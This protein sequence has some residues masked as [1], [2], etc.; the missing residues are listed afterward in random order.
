MLPRFK[1]YDLRVVGHYLGVLISFFSLALLLP[2]ITAVCMQEWEAASR[3]LLGAGLTLALGSLMRMLRIEPGKLTQSQALAITGFAWIIL[4]VVA[5]VPLWLSGHYGS[6]LD[7]LF[8]SVSALTTTGAT[9]V[10]DLEH[11]SYADNMWRFTMHFIGGLG[12]IV[13][14]LSLGLLGRSAWGMYL[15]EGRSDHVLPNVVNTARLISG[16]AFITIAIAVV[17]LGIFCLFSGMEPVRAFFH[18]LWIAVSGYMTAGF[19]PT[20]QSIMYYHSFPLEVVCILLMVLGA[21]NFALLLEV[22][23]GKTKAF[24]KDLEIRTAALWLL[25]MCVVLMASMSAAGIYSDL[26]TL[27]R[28]GVFMLISAATT[29]GFQVVTNNQLVT[30]FSSGAIL[31]LAVV[32]AV[33]GSSGS[34]SGGIKFMRI[35]LI[36]KAVVSSVKET[37]LPES[38]RSSVVYHHLTKHVLTADNIKIAT[39][40]SALFIITYLLGALIGI[41]HG[42]DAVASI[43]ESVAMASNGGLSSGIISRGMPVGLEV[44]YIIE[45]WAGRLEFI[46]LLALFVKIV[47]SCIPQKKA[48][49]DK[50]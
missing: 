35:G 2:L 47:A 34:T 48:G 24:F 50:K 16:I 19:A 5:A 20:S 33:G 44:F 31:I 1:L 45:M 49:R 4:A 7:T 40:V 29:T 25:V 36:A 9:L 43:F 12:L 39:T 14:A 28:R 30:V 15:S 18:S 3:Y 38:A 37:L 32:M 46:A 13:V 22:W 17:F 21:I 8:E 6:F 42:Y 23:K 41:A 10:V 26:P 27:L 11:M